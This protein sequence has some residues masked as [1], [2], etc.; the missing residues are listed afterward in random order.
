MAGSPTASTCPP[1][2]TICLPRMPPSGTA[3]V[4]PLMATAFSSAAVQVA[5]MP[6]FAVTLPPLM[7]TVLALNARLQLALT[8][9]PLMVRRMVLPEA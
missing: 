4:P 1:E 3:T 7:D 5:R 2:I 6:P 8:V 9:P